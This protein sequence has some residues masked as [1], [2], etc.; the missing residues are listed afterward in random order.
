ME[1][2]TKAG[3]YEIVGE[4]G[5]GAMG[6][7]Y[8][9]V[10]PVI[11]RT[12]AV[13]TIRLSEEGTGLSR[14]ELLTR[15]QTEAR[16]AGLLTHPNIVVVFDAGEEDGLYYIT[17]ELV[18]G[19]SLQVLLDGGHSFPLPRTLR[20]ME[21][22][23]SALQFAHERNV[24]HRDIK[25]ANLM[26][27][28]DDTVK[29]TDF[30]TAKILQFG[31][32]QQTSH[33]MGTPSYMSPEQ[34]KGRAVDGRSD[35]FSLGVMLYEMVAAEKPF[36][37]QNIT[38]VIYKIV[39]EDPVPPRQI[40]PSIHPGISAVVMRAL[41]KEP[42]QRYQSC[43]QMLED[44][45]NYRNLG[46]AANPNS[47]M[48]MGGASPAA[49]VIS[50]NP[51][52]RNFPGDDPSVM[53]TV[54]SLS[55]RAA[56]PGQTPVV[57][58]TGIITPPVEPPKK[59]KKS[60]VGT[61]FAALLLLGV[62][63]YGA[64]KIK[65]VFEAARELHDAQV[66]GTEPPTS[67]VGTPSSNGASSDATV[68]NAGSGSDKSPAS[69]DPASSAPEPKETEAKPVEPVS[70]KPAPRKPESPLN[71]KAA[72]YKGRIEEVIAARGLT[73]RVKVQ[74]VSNTLTLA[75]RLRPGEHADLLKFLRNAPSDV[76]VVD[77]IE[78]DD[79]PVAVASSADESS[80]PVPAAGRGAIHV[81]TD[82]T[83]ATATLH[84]PAGHVLSKC[85]TPCSF[86]NLKPQ[87]YGLEVQ[88]DG[89]QPM[90]T[91]LQI[92]GD[93]AQDQKIKLES[94]AK[95][96]FIST[97]PAGADVFINGAKQ[98]G[99]TPVTL[100]LAPGQYNLVLR[101]QGYE[102]YSGGIQ[103][104]DIQTQLNVEL[105]QK[106]ASRVAWAQV[107]SNPKGAE[108]IVDGN[109]TG[110]FTPS[111]VQIPSGIHTIMLRLNGY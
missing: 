28:A 88:K 34:V 23:C 27:T 69:S 110:Q 100:P 21:Q 68:E 67:A 46:S 29:I 33:V 6:I 93:E 84:G 94:L 83:G 87:R 4:L 39:N 73:G 41:A 62:I 9:A 59:K 10:D 101:L 66:K 54:H 5:R 12:V 91:A 52:A 16:A 104:K 76:H 92:K 56:S 86:N 102:P 61:I 3:R 45:R 109:S 60:V 38:T 26:L 53:A 31:T 55:S 99:Q 80:H 49:T 25:P 1:T 63:T 58:R 90:Q 89:Y 111:R 48:V 79:S 74:G 42:E 98:S 36:P 44:L 32:M 85:E 78:Y 30:G 19:K 106:S 50:A 81:V 70:E 7:V 103:V 77:H 18:E 95:G 35:I 43:R 108:I 2:V 97:Q 40:D 17:M 51:P 24:V 20:I 57:R 71:A 37:G 13:K 96:I 107:N 72:E 64:N 47:T 65:P 105:V 15:F 8:K 75:G 11:G 22:T 14:P 82:V